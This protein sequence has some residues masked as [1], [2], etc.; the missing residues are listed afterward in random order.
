MAETRWKLER[1]AFGGIILHVRERDGDRGYQCFVADRAEA[2]AM[3]PILRIEFAAAII[4]GETPPAR[5]WDPVV[6]EP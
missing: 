1:S 5:L 2:R 3:L 6:V 4:R